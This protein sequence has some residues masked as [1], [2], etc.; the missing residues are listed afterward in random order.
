PASMVTVCLVE[1]PSPSTTTECSPGVRSA[2]ITGDAP[3]GTPS[4]VTRAPAG[5][6]FTCRLP[7]ATRPLA[8]SMYW[9]NCS[10]AATSSDIVRGSPAPRNSRTWVPGAT[11]NLAGETPCVLPSRNTCAPG[12]F[13][14]TTTVPVV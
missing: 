6:V 9:D 1:P 7:A 13:V 14:V 12:G 3:R 10:P 5:S 11:V 8:I 4:T 2:T